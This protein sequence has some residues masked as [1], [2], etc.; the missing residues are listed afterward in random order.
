MD[1]INKAGETIFGL[2]LTGGY[3]IT[4]I[5]GGGKVLNAIAK[6]DAA[7]AGKTALSYGVAYASLHLLKWVLSLIREAF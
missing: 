7:E 1:G 3:W 5:A 4:L 6:K 2:L